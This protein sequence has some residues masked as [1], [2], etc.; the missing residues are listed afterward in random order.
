MTT[1]GGRKPRP[2]MT[3]FWARALRRRRCES[4]PSAC[5][6]FTSFARRTRFNL[7]L[8]LSGADRP[9]GRALIV[10]DGNL[11]EAAGA[12]GFTIILL[13]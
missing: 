1:K 2:P 4:V 12:E 5:F 8:L 7:P 6:V 3:A 13:S 9:R 11:V 10:A